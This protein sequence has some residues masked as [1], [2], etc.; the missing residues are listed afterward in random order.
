MHPLARPGNRSG[1]LGMKAGDRIRMLARTG[2]ADEFLQD[3]DC[4]VTWDDGEHGIVK[5]RGIWPE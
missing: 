2:T 5:W 3:G 1:A 4:L